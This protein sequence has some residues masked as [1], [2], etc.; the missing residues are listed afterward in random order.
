MVSGHP[1]KN[2]HV[3]TVP[4]ESFQMAQ[5]KIGLT[6]L[7]AKFAPLE[8][9]ILKQVKPRVNYVRSANSKPSSLYLNVDTVPSERPRIQLD[10]H[11]VTN[12][13]MASMSI[14]FF[15]VKYV[16]WANKDFSM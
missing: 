6:W 2:L 5:T 12:V 8:H 13:H 16:H 9:K 11:L 14:A 4:L 10:R 3:K 7:H 1:S 15:N